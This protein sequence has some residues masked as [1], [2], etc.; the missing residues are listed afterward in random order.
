MAEIDDDDI[1]EFIQCETETTAMR[2]GIKSAVASDIARTL[3][4]I[5]RQR[6]SGEL[7]YIRKT[8]RTAKNELRRAVMAD[9]N[10]NNHNAV[11]VRHGIS[12]STLYR[13]MRDCKTAETKQ[14]KRQARRAA[15]L[16][17]FNGFNHAEICD[18]YHISERL[19]YRYL[20]ELDTK[21]LK[22]SKRRARAAAVLSDLGHEAPEAVCDKHGISR[23]TLS[24]YKKEDGN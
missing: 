2:F 23:S 4:E 22:R 16:A 11:C 14:A 18:K 15:V 10:G 13:F 7:T 17:E 5:V 9:F 19:L 12:P 20:Q 8:N 21:S 6:Y 24:R 3:S 1:L